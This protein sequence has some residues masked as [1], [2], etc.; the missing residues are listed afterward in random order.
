MSP[1]VELLSSV[2]EKCPANRVNIQATRV[3]VNFYCGKLDDSDTVIPALKGLVPLCKLPTFTSS[4]A[5][6]TIE[7]IIRHVTMKVQVQSTRYMVFRIVDTLLSRYREDLKKM[8]TSFLRG[9][10]N[11]AEGEKDPR[12]LLLAFSIARVLLIEFDVWTLID[13]FFNI[14]FCYFPI[15]FKP[16]PNDPYGITTDDLK[17]ALR[18]ALTATPHFG[19]LALPLFLEKISIGSPT[20]KRDS[21][22]AISESFPVYGPVIAREFATQLWNSLKLEIFQPT[23]D[24]TENAALFTTQALI[25]CIYSD[26]TDNEN[27]QGLARDICEECGNILKEPEKSRAKPAIKVI[28]ALIRTSPP[29][30]HFALEQSLPLLFKL[31]LDPA[32][33]STRPATLSALSSILE[34]LRELASKADGRNVEEE[35]PLEPYKDQLLGVL[36]V[37][38]K[39]SNTCVTALQG[40]LQWINIPGALTSEELGFVVHSVNEAAMT[41]DAEEDVREAALT[42]LKSVSLKEPHHI[43]ENTLPLLFASL[44]DRGPERQATEERAYIWKTL[45]ALEKLCAQPSLFETLVV[46]LSSK[47]ELLCSITPLQE[48]P[49]GRAEERECNAA[50]AH[51]MLMTLSNVFSQKLDEKHTDLPKYLNR[52]IPR[53]YNL[54]VYFAYNPEPQLCVA[55]HPH[56]IDAASRIIVLTM[57]SLNVEDQTAFVKQLFG[58]YLEGQFGSILEGHF[59]IATNY[60]F[61]PFKDG[62][63]ESQRSLSVLFSAPLL[64]LRTE[65][66]LPVESELA[67]FRSMLLWSVSSQSSDAQSVSIQKA[68]AAVLNRH[69]EGL[70]QFLT[71]DA[72]AFWAEHI[73]SSSIDPS[74]R[75]RALEGWLWITKALVVRS[76]PSALQFADLLF[77]VFDDPIIGWTA[78]RTLGQIA[79]ASDI[80]SKKYF[81]VVRILHT[82]KYVQHVLPRA[83]EGCEWKGPDATQQTPY[84]IAVA[85]L[86]KSVPRTLYSGQ[87]TKLMPFLL[88]GLELDD[89]DLRSSI[90]DVIN[91][92]A[93]EEAPESK[94]ISEYASSLVSIMLKIVGPSNGQPVGVRLAALR[95]LGVLPSCVRYDVLHPSK[96]NVIRQ[97]G[98][99]LDDPKRSVRKEAV[100][101][102]ENWYSYHG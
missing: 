59:K 74:L 76:H 53:L 6:Q 26:S 50:Y 7:S 37:G 72:H 80:L 9:Y 87:L 18:K 69:V 86:I 97:L 10:I 39:S 40:L 24:I 31:F 38:L 25:V 35:Q 5:I 2:L 36:T 57:R 99:V 100:T 98:K 73:Q 58:L 55:T 45:G 12:N 52:L 88:R 4:D 91:E 14:T 70:S 1:G 44:P 20:I 93:S 16:P 71:S 84:L 82:Q 79:K 22:S 47:V 21:L 29:I 92:A 17:D 81:A 96:S 41:K 65:V 101:A 68:L 64:A 42:L 56:L 61:A 48:A 33:I 54:F 67:F 95:C 90:I 28:A 3:L 15:T 23:D 11:L 89:S 51:A 46:K 85:S 94:L 49:D 19:R 27:I 77:T 78:A 8:G 62:A 102:R 32:E 60:P 83:L 43:E 30:T 75:T 13:D 34:S 66:K 63:P